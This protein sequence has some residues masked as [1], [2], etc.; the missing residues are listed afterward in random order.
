MVFMRLYPQLLLGYGSFYDGL[1][2]I[3]PDSYG[4]DSNDCFCLAIG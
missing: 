2:M 4:D 3:G 1:F